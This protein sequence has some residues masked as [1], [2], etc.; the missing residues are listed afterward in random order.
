MKKI[1]FIS[2]AV[3]LII[4]S[5][6]PTIVDTGKVYVTYF[7]TGSGDSVAY[8]YGEI[9]TEPED[10]VLEGYSFVG[11]YRDWSESN[12]FEN[13]LTNKFK[14][15]E[16]IGFDIDLY[17]AYVPEEWTDPDTA[18]GRIYSQIVSGTEIEIRTRE[19]LEAL[20][21]IVS[22]Y[23][24]EEFSGFERS[25]VPFDLS[26][27]GYTV[28]IMND[29]DLGGDLWKPIGVGLR[30]H[31]QI[32]PLRADIVGAGNGI[33]ISGLRVNGLY[34]YSGFIAAYGD[35]FVDGISIVGTVDGQYL[36]GLF[37][38]SLYGNVKLNN[39]STS[40]T[41]IGGIAGGIAGGN[42][43]IAGMNSY[44]FSATD[45]TNEAEISG[46]EYAGGLVG[47]CDC[48]NEVSLRNVANTGAVTGKYAGGIIADLICNGSVD[49]Q[50]AVNRGTIKGE[51]SAAG[52]VS[53]ISTESLIAYD[54]ENH[55]DITSDSDAASIGGF[56]GEIGSGDVKISGGTIIGSI[57]APSGNAG[58][59]LGDATN[60]SNSITISDITSDAALSLTSN[61]SD[62]FKSCGGIFGNASTDII[63][64][65]NCSVRGTIDVSGPN[66][67]DERVGG[68]AGSCIFNEPP[69]T[70][71]GCTVSAAITAP[72]V[73]YLGG[74]VGMASIGGAD[75]DPLSITD[76]QNLTGLPDEGG[77]N[78]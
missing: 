4:T 35:G 69:M 74:Y 47:C 34:G 42:G 41:V 39:V 59:V 13:H 16:T 31:E 76:S 72:G 78:W 43:T 48:S 33:K 1:L 68:I 66:S 12:G 7:A 73:Y 17:A 8:D 60:F 28:K 14:F 50:N 58:G 67:N 27:Y 38:G 3:L 30:N 20:D 40:G 22:C 37:A 11:W 5:C 19:D 54:S 61:R 56:F 18:V 75:T 21:E 64:I 29:I 45:V 65:R 57:S 2:L 36:S 63:N 44:S 23:Q 49:I 55:G 15:G 51:T 26:L 53:F 52:I 77:G 10:P 6:A 70:I 9:V 62:V 46:D 71:S 32:F 24:E 25:R